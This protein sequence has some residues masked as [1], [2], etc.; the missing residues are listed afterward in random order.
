MAMGHVSA[1]VAPKLSLA[2]GNI[3]TK[4]SSKTITPL[5]PKNTQTK[6]FDV[7]AS[8]NLVESEPNVSSFTTKTIFDGKP[9]PQDKLS[10]LIRYLERRNVQVYGTSG[11]PRFVGMWDGSGQI[12]W[13]QT[14]TILQ[15]KHEL[16]HFLDFKKYGVKDFVQLTRHEREKL[17][18]ERLKKN[19]SWLQ[20]NDAE[21]KFSIQYVKNLE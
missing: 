18:L 13:P 14:P 1:S 7:N 5:P 21:R 6:I 17:V 10:S 9:Y 2:G 16:S 11:N 4:A 19:R 20:F 8:K 15:V 12:Y 3:F